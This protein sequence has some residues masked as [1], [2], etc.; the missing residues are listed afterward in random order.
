MNKYLAGP[1]FIHNRLSDVIRSAN[2]ECQLEK[3]ESIDFM[4]GE[5][6]A[7]FKKS[8]MSFDDFIKKSST[9]WTFV[10]TSHT[11]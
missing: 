8:G 9:K 11:L 3:D 6:L 10:S 4:L 5:I 2:S 1:L 7:Y